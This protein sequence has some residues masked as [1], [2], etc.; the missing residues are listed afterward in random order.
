MMIIPPSAVVMFLF[1]KKLNEAA[2]LSVPTAPSRP[3]AWA[4]SSKSRRPN[5]SASA[6]HC[7][8]STQ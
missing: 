7:G 4:A 2:S 3:A 1:V 6:R 8:M 5:S